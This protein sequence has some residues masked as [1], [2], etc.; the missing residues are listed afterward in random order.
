[1]STQ[2]PSVPHMRRTS[3]HTVAHACVSHPYNPGH[4]THAPTAGASGAFPPAAVLGIDPGFGGALAWLDLGG[5]LHVEDMPTLAVERNGKTK[6]DLDLAALVELVEQ[7]RP[8]F[9]VV[10]RV[11]AMPGQGVSS[12][13]AFGRGFGS[14]LGVLAALRV[15]V[16]LVTPATWKRA[17]SV[18]A[19]KDGARLRAS[20]LLPAHGGHWRHAKD[21][22]RAEASMLA[23]YGLAY[24]S[25]RP[26][27]ALG[28][29][30]EST[31][32][33]TH[34]DLARDTD[35]RVR[36]SNGD[37]EVRLNVPV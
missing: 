23:W 19:G 1:M 11:G 9:A 27:F 24:L 18:P 6:R 14:I 25:N 13:F 4:V 2:N 17:L 7:H 8:A 26:G 34:T 28:N 20:Q 30:Q 21:D 16:E 37:S 31:G 22:G 10:E 36:A 32:S 5:D 15:P 33:E 29:A 35:A 12:M 3:F